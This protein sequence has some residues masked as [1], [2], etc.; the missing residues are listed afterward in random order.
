MEV[1]LSAPLSTKSVSQQEGER[2]L[3]FSLGQ[4]DFAV[5]LLKVREVIEMPDITP[6]PHTP[7]YFLGIMNLRGE[8]ISVMDLGMKLKGKKQAIGNKTAVIILDLGSF[9][10]GI[11]AGA[12]NRVLS[13]TEAE[14]RSCPD[15][16]GRESHDYIT[17]VIHHN[18]QMILLL[19]LQKALDLRDLDF[20]DSQANAA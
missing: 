17:G 12:V 2:Y 20:I 16:Q 19:D 5:S 4:E 6:V 11:V 1:S 9:R 13:V 10:V 7:G 14:I 15:V 18:R 3:F 8:V